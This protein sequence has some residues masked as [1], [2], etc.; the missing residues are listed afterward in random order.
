MTLP[1][2]LPFFPENPPPPAPEALAAK[3]RSIVQ[4][5]WMA[6]HFPR[7]AL[8]AS[9]ISPQDSEPVALV[10]G[11]G[12]KAF[13][14]DCTDGATCRGVQHGQLINSALALAPA[15]KIVARQ[16]AVEQTALR[17]L[18]K[19][20]YNFTPSVS[21]E[22]PASLLLEVG[23]STHLFG[24]ASDLVAQARGNFAKSGFMPTLALAPT[25]IAALWLARAKF[26]ISIT[27]RSE[28]RSVLGR[29]P[30]QVIAWSKESWNSFDR[31]G[32]KHLI[33][34]FRLPRDGL[35]RRFG[36]D[37]VRTLDRALG[38][39]PDP[40]SFWH[41]PKCCRLNRDL[42]GELTRIDHILPYVD[43]MVENLDSELQ[44]HD[45]A[46]TGMKLVFRHRHQPP[47][48][49]LVRSSVPYRQASCWM[50]LIRAK[51]TDLTT[52]A[53]VH[54]I[55]L[56]SDRFMPG[57]AVSFDMFGGRTSTRESIQ[58]LVDL[59][60]SRLG[61]QAVF[62]MTANADFRPEHTFRSVE[63][64][65]TSPQSRCGLPRPLH[66]LPAPVL[67]RFSGG[68]LRH[69]SSVLNLLTGPERIEGGWWAQEHWIR[70]YYQA[71]SSSGVRLWIFHEGRQWFLHGLYS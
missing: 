48:I 15:L 64:G 63:P 23:G 19:L 36:K 30:I 46:I 62:S 17:R 8:Q 3:P 28:L 9:G 25:P 70:D 54:E 40:R 65:E 32:I 5:L 20:G 14:L 49:V 6:V 67:L 35:A 45:A 27:Q 61:P 26:E 33:D 47:T 21:L 50:E 55:Q 39:L 18:A 66:L 59:L 37:F 71:L 38:Q 51:L 43:S 10:E 58:R 52:L 1:L 60:R 69:R 34:V 11:Q 41:G 31:L 7:L 42:P 16:N 2:P 12:Q 4:A 13:I 56:V 22:S 53:P 57:T 29:L 24:G 68:R 44:G